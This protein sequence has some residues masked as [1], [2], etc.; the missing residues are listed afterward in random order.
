MMYNA[1]KDHFADPTGLEHESIRTFC[2]TKCLT[3]W[4][5]ANTSAICRERCGGGS[6]LSSSEIP[7]GM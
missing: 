6:F 5:M 7:H 4:N 3:T 1:A 2:A